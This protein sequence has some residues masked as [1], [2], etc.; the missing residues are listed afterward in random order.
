MAPR[1]T[2]AGC[3]NST[4]ESDGTPGTES[5]ATRIS[6]ARTICVESRI[7]RG[8][9]TRNKLRAAGRPPTNRFESSGA[10]SGVNTKPSKPP[11]PAGLT[12]GCR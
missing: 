11:P 9:F 3:T 12:G 2:A 10:A 8:S 1:S 5:E 7:A 6:V 4:K